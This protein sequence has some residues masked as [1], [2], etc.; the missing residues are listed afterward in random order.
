VSRDGAL[1]LN[2]IINDLQCQETIVE[3]VDVLPFC[4]VVYRFVVVLRFVLR[5]LLPGVLSA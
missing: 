3:F 4:F 1:H 5:P 2:M